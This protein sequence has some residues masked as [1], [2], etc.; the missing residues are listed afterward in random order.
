MEENE[1]LEKVEKIDAQID[2]LQSTAGKEAKVLVKK[3]SESI[4]KLESVTSEYDS[5]DR[6]S[7]EI[8]K[9]KEIREISS[10]EGLPHDCP[11]CLIHCLHFTFCS[12]PGFYSGVI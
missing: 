11:S 9:L 7:K 4:E 6:H 3:T 12:D 8:E 5:W 1:N 2:A 10:G